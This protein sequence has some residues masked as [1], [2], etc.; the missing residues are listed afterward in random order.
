MTK[1]NMKIKNHISLEDKI[2]A[3]NIMAHS[4][5]Q[6]NESN[7]T[8]YAPYLKEVGKVIAAAKY[9]IEGITFVIRKPEALLNFRT[10]PLPYWLISWLCLLTAKHKKPKPRQ[11][12]LQP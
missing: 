11:K 3:I 4:Y 2:H 7:E 8:E 5:F 12:P 10:K 9:F 1:T 6:E